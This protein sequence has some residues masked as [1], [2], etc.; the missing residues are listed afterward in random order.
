MILSLLMMLHSAKDVQ[1]LLSQ[2]SSAFS[3][4]G[5][6]IS[7]KKAK[8]LYQGTDILQSIKLIGNDV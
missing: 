6:K 8:V 1:T 3:D 4:F 7:D 5:I 2:F